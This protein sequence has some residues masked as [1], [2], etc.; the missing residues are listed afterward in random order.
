M[1]A[2]EVAVVAVVVVTVVA[3]VAVDAVGCCC[4]SCGGHHAGR[5][6][7]KPKSKRVKRGPK[8]TIILCCINIHPRILDS[9]K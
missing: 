3:V 8:F 5:I 7:G 6:V 2:V 1:K 9:S 4:Q